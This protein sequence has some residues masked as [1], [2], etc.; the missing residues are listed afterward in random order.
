[1]NDSNAIYSYDLATGEKKELLNWINSDINGNTVQNITAL[2]NGNFIAIQY[3]YENNGSSLLLLVPKDPSEIKEKTVITFAAMYIQDNIR[4]AIINFNK[5]NEEYRIQ[6]TDYSQ[7]NTQEDY[8][9]GLLNLIMIL[10]PAISPI[11]WI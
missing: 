11:L 2:T 10:F 3:N 5:T 9:R 4:K 1:M 7:Y 6:V 8:A